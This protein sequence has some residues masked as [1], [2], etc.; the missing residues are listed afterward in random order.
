MRANVTEIEQV[1]EI[2]EDT[3][4]G[5]LTY[6]KDNL[7]PQRI[8][9][10]TSRSGTAMGCIRQ[11]AK[12]ITG[13]GFEDLKFWKAKVNRKGL[14]LDQLLRA[15]SMQYARFYGYAVQ[16]NYN[17]LYQI[18][19]INIVPFE[20]CR[21]AIPDD[22]GFIG[23]I[24]V[25]D[26]WDRSK[27]RVKP[28]DIDFINVFNPKP[29]AIQAQVD[30]AGGWDH[31]KGQIIYY[32]GLDDSILYPV[33]NYDAVLHDIRTDGALQVLRNTNVESNFMIDAILTTY[34]KFEKDTDRQEFNKGIEKFQGPRAKRI[35]HVE[36]DEAEG[37]KAPTLE[38]FEAP[39]RDKIFEVTE[40]S[41]R[42][43]II[44]SFMQPQIL[45][46]GE[47]ADKIG[48]NDELDN[49]YKFY[50]SVTNDDRQ[51]FEELFMEIIPLY[52][53][54]INPTGNYAIKKLVFGA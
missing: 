12:F 5:I 51:L 26:N 34:G 44:T 30:V 4:Y 6:D 36:V 24:A 42:K 40:K 54:I 41:V 45:H 19:E 22:T 9:A 37:E 21:L 38:T 28:E 47:V 27:G 43:S 18:D 50:N 20:H 16:F 33:P 17:A 32:T 49:A 46:N 8:L 14:R 29:E 3:K 11:H 2:K 23:K 52:K 1:I 35:L 53:D 10:D 39:D 48:A 25:Y 13:A 15:L 7:Y 31:Y